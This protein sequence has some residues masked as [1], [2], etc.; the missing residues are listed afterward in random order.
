VS[1]KELKARMTSQRLQN[2]KPEIFFDQGYPL[3][4]A[5]IKGKSKI[6]VRFQAQTTDATAGG[7]FGLR[8]LKATEK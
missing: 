7:V 3:P 2:N 4:E 6:T 5:M 1:E 8:I